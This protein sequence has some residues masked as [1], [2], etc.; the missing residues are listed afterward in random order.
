MLITSK[1]LDDARR[2][3]LLCQFNQLETGVRSKWS[4]KDACQDLVSS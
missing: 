3:D 4:S 2:K 1:H